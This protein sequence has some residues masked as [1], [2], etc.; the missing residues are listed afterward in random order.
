MH[1]LTLQ[2]LLFAFATCC[3]VLQLAARWN[4]LT[5]L[6][7]FQNKAA[8]YA[9][10]TLTTGGGYVWFFF[11]ENRN[12]PGLEGAQQS[13]GFALGGFLGLVFTLVLASLIHRKSTA[14]LNPSWDEPG[15]DALRKMNYFQA[16][17][18]SFRTGSKKGKECS[19]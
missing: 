13:A 6:S 1:W 4:K 11:S 2:Y 10:A 12:F 15:L 19:G 5:G 14:G 3:G 9:F 16:L 7:F 8:T 18:H 17:K